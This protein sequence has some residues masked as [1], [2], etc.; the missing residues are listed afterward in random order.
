M[1]QE[2]SY[3]RLRSENGIRTVENR[4]N[5]TSCSTTSFAINCNDL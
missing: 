3:N 5:R 4:K 2:R 1:E